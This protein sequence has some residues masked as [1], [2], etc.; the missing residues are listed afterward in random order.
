[1]GVQFLRLD[2]PS[3]EVVNQMLARKAAGPPGAVRA[4]RMSMPAGA[5]AA[6]NGANGTSWPAPRVDTS[7]DLASEMGVDEVRLKR[8]VERNWIGN[9]RAS[10]EA[11]EL[12]AL[13]RPEAIE[14]VSL[15]QALAELP[16]LLDPPRDG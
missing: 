13:L 3:R 4:I 8:A 6:R 7:V 15:A 5:G 16:R 11:D 12:E 2:A 9:G 1:M 10:G 14:P